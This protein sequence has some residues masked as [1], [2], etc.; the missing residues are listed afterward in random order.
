MADEKRSAGR[1]SIL[2]ERRENITLTGVS[3]VISFDDETVVTDTEM[4][5]VIIK[6]NNLH[7]S[8]LNLDSGDLEVDG[9]ILSITYE[10][11]SSYG[12]NKGSFFGKLF[13]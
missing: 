4:G 8:R 2:I 6:G 5:A 10:D 13:K 1:H 3:D 7:V 9:N 11:N 12:K